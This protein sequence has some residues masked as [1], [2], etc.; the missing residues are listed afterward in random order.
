M[1]RQCPG[2]HAQACHHTSPPVPLR[3]HQLLELGQAV[4]NS[5]SA[6]G[7][8]VIHSTGALRVPPHPFRDRVALGLDVFEEVLDLGDL[9]CHARVERIEAA[10]D[11]RVGH[12]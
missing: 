7:W 4:R 6:A 3:Q 9:L 10:L 11:L 1:P 5:N 8:P 2:L 12:A